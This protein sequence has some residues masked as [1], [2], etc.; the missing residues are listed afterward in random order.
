MRIGCSFRKFQLFYIYCLNF[1]FILN[2]LCCS[3]PTGGRYCD[4]IVGKVDKDIHATPMYET[5]A[6]L[7]PS[8]CNKKR[9][10]ILYLKHL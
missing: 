6:I 8:L 4:K 9:L 7:Y 5:V 1:K 10:C 2:F 3:D